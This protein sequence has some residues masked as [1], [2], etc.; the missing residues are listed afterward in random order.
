[1]KVKLSAMVVLV[2]FLVACGSNE[3]SQIQESNASVTQKQAV[4][5]LT[6]DV[7][8]A[9][10]PDGVLKELKSGNE[11]FVNQTPQYRDLMA[12]VKDTAAGQ[13]PSAVVLSCID[14]RIPTEM[15]LDQGI[16]DI[17]NARVAGN[18]VNAE[19]LGSMEFA[20]A[21][22]GAKLVVVMGHTACGAVKGACDNVELG[23]VTSLVTAIQPSVKSVAGD[24]CSSSDSKLVDSV[25]G[26]NVTRT[27]SEI[28]ERS[29]ILANLEKEGKIQIV[30]AMYDIGTGRVTF[31]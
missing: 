1:M 11:R 29:E 14:S 16:G 8:D 26:H 7:R 25:A 2:G 19:I 17:F 13:Y 5:A 27:I 21:V 9:M 22:A 6:K 28:R 23:N 10:T 30:G 31:M 4:P 20:T 24:S 3:S 12:Q 18:I 15:V